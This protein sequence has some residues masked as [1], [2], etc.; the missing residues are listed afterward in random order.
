MVKVLISL[1]SLAATAGYET[2]RV[3]DQAHRFLRKPLR[4]LLPIR[5]WR[6]VQ[7]CYDPPGRTHNTDPITMLS[8]QN[9]ALLTKILSDN[10]PKLGDDGCLPVI[11]R[12]EQTLAGVALNKLEEMEAVVFTYTA[13][14]Y[15]ELDQKYPLLIGTPTASTSL[16]NTEALLKNTTLDDLRTIVEYK[17]IHASFNHLSPEF[18]TANWNF[19]GKIIDG[20]KVEPTREQFCIAEVDKTVGELLGQYFLDEVWSAET[21]KAV[22]ELVKALESS[23]STGIAT[24]DW[25]DDSTRANAQTKLSKFVYLLGGPENP[26][27]YP[28]LTLDSKSYF[29]NR[30]KVSQVNIDTNL[31]LAGQPVD[32]RKFDVPPRHFRAYREYLKKFPSQYTEDAGDKLFYL[33]FA[34][35]RCS[36]NT[37]AR[38]N[39]H[40]TDP[41]PPDRFR[42]TGALENDA[43]FA[44]VFKCPTDSCLNPSNKCLLWE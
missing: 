20:E 6:V 43:E 42:V 3:C 5:V 10:K 9:Q 41:H 44:R 4:R 13:F 33:S 2:P 26:Q 23:T 24:A 18:R 31:K 12:F 30:W 28:T 39:T 11:I 34:Q 14:T 27:L 8:I 1:I 19:F 38:L 35:A 7:G 17:L 36:K 21:A 32:N 37:D 16:D 40:L 15:Y 22:D 25:L 29:N